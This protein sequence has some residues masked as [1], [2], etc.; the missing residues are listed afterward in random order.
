MNKKYLDLIYR[1]GE[2]VKGENKKYEYCHLV[3]AI[4]KIEDLTIKKASEE[5]DFILDFKGNDIGI[6]IITLID[7]E[8]KERD[9]FIQN[10]LNKISKDISPRHTD[11]YLLNI[12]FTKSFEFDRYKIFNE[13]KKVIESYLVDE[14]L[15]DNDYI[16][17]ILKGGKV[18]KEM[19]LYYNHGGFRVP[20]LTEEILN[21]FI[22]K[23][24]CKIESYKKNLNNSA[25]WLL[26]VTNTSIFNYD[27][28]EFPPSLTTEHDFDKILLLHDFKNELFEWKT[29]HWVKV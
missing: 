8:K 18:K 25:C 1:E 29:N 3:K 15:I 7:S 5:P 21:D 24:N 10:I 6:E 27:I 17:D 23:K 20:E 2:F 16:C 9:G 4:C 11:K 19:E 12:Y 14:V 13:C 22:N 28:D 26:L